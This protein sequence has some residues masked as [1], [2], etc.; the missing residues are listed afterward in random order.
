MSDFRDKVQSA[1]G[2]S[3]QFTNDGGI[4]KISVAGT[5]RNLTLSANSE[6]RRQ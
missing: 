6:T 4:W 1:F 3:V 5:G 2:S